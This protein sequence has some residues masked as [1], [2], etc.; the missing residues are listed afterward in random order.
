[1]LPP[2]PT[3]CVAV[4]LFSMFSSSLLVGLSAAL[5]FPSAELRL[6]HGRGVVL[7][8]A[9]VFAFSLVFPLA[10]V[11][12]RVALLTALALAFLVALVVVVAPFPFAF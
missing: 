7:A 5:A 11:G 12:E 6:G 4:L 1:M 3:A 8:L 9:L 2:R 10:L